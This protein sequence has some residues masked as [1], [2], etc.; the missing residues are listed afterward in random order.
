MTKETMTI[1]AR[2]QAALAFLEDAER[3]FAAG[4]ARQAS[5]KLWGAATDAITAVALERGWNHES[6][7]DM[8]NVV[9]R[10]AVEPGNDYLDAQFI[11]AEKFHMN[12][13]QTMLEDYEIEVD[14]RIVYDFVHRTLAL[15]PSEQ[16][17]LE[18]SK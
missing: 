15:L 9:K 1:A 13:F 2:A 14:K 18:A 7:R 11:A 17:T 6:H 12:F 16:K 5:E 4:D 8:K 10:L 3:E